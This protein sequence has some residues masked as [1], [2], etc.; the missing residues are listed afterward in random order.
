M[1]SWPA[2]SRPV[3]PV[4]VCLSSLYLRVRSYQSVRAHKLHKSKIAR[5]KPCKNLVVGLLGLLEA[6]RD[7]LVD[8]RAYGEG[9]GLPALRASCRV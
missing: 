7:E 8:L 5:S 6:Q 4:S 2:S 1:A 9:R 3:T